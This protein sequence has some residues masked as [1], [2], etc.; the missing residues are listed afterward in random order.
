MNIDIIQAIFCS[1][2]ESLWKIVLQ[3]WMETPRRWTGCVVQEEET[4]VGGIRQQ[5]CGEKRKIYPS[6]FLILSIKRTSCFTNLYA[7]NGAWQNNLDYHLDCPVQS[8][9]FGS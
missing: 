9:S 2:T 8:T 3:L 6:A 7:M 1:L 4:T 5:K